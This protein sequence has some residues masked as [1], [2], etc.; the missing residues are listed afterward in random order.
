MKM[1]L[2][3]LRLQH[4][5]SVLCLVTQSCLS[6]CN[7]MNCSLPGSSVH[8]DSP[9]KNTGVGWHA[10]LQGIFPT[11]G[12][13]PCLPHCRRILYCMSH[14]LCAFKY[15]R[16]R[17]AAMKWA[18]TSEIFITSS[19]QRYWSLDGAQR[20]CSERAMMLSDCKWVGVTWTLWREY[21]TP[22][23]HQASCS[24][25]WLMAL[26][27]CHNLSLRRWQRTKDL[28]SF[29]HISQMPSRWSGTSGCCS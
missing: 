9:G 14:L 27:T 29:K 13:N 11:Q 6:L 26:A 20:T 25:Q 28:T 17:S 4:Y 21:P 10:L 5:H 22:A 15:F 12:L 16:Y 19:S 18:Q 2:K 1:G 23:L 24:W 8:G 7:P 3:T